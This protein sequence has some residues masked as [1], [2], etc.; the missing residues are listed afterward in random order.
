MGKERVHINEVQYFKCSSVD[1][2]IYF[3][4]SFQMSDDKHIQPLT[5]KIVK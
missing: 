5:D 2:A 4:S 3:G 1:F